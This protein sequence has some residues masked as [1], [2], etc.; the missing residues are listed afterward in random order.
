MPPSAS[1]TWPAR[2][3]SIRQFGSSAGRDVTVT[4]PRM[5]ARWSS[6]RVV[7]LLHFAAELVAEQAAERAGEVAALVGDLAG[8]AERAVR[9]WSRCSARSTRRSPR[10]VRAR[11][12]SR[13]RPCR[14]ARRADFRS[15]RSRSRGALASMRVADGERGDRDRRDDD[16]G[17]RHRLQGRQRRGHRAAFVE[18]IA[19]EEAVERPQRAGEEKHDDASA[20][21]GRG[22][23]GRRAGDARFCLMGIIC[24]EIIA[25]SAAILGRGS[26]CQFLTRS[27]RRREVIRP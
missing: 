10:S 8:D 23:T 4:L 16:R 18:R 21:R 15:C 12:S 7:E 1:E 9:A 17:A 20:E 13:C 22:P 27:Y 2:F 14:A 25:I 3:G 19:G 26:M 24:A 11:W 6:A 5:S